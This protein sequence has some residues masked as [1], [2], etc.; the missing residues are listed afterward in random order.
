MAVK[1]LDD[2][3]AEGVSG[4]GVLVRSDLNV[5]VLA[6]F[7]AGHE[8]PNLTIPLGTDVELVAEENVGWIAY[9]EEALE[10]APGREPAAPA[11]ATVTAT[12]APAASP[13]PP[14]AAPHE[15]VPAHAPAA[16][17]P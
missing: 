11:P 13:A 10:E 14:S 6:D 1:T 12:A 17:A 7:P 8:V 5:P 4:R 2:L 3:L 16:V 9:R 15:V